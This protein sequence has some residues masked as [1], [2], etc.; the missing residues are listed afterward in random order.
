MDLQLPASS[1]G[2]FSLSRHLLLGTAG[3]IDHGKT[4]LVRVLTGTDTDRLPEEKARGM[5]IELGFAALEVG[6]AG[7]EAVRFGIVD[8]P[9]HE[10]FVRTMVAGATG[11]D[12]VLLVVAADDSVMPQT[13]EHVDILKLLNVRRGVV[14]ITKCDLVDPEMPA[15]VEEEVREL[16]AGSPLASAP[17][18]PVSAH[19]GVGLDVLRE[20]LLAEAGQIE[21]RRTSGIFRLPI[22]RVFTVHGRGTVVTG[23]A[24][25]GTVTVGQALELLPAR[26]PC[27]VR[28]LQTHSDNADLLHDGQRVAVNLAGIGREQIDRGD[29]LATVGYLTPSEYLDVEITALSANA[30]ALRHLQNVRL[31]MGTGEC[32]VRLRLLGGGSGSNRGR[33]V[34]GLAPG[35]RGFAQLQSERPVVAEWHQRFILRDETDSRTVGGGLVLRPVS[36]RLQRADAADIDGLGVLRSGDATAR[37]EEIIRFARVGRFAKGRGQLD[38]LSIASAAGISAEAIAPLLD[39]L[40]GQGRVR[41]LG[42]QGLLVPLAT[43]DRCARQAIEKLA[44]F[45]RGH[46]DDPGYS[47]PS[48]E[49]WVKRRWGDEV[50]G[51]LV[52]HLL[53]TGGWRADHPDCG[54]VRV[55][56]RYCCLSEF[57]PKMSAE[58]ERLLRAIIDEYRDAAFQPPSVTALRSTQSASSSRVTKL[59]KIAT[60]TGQLVRISPD[61]LM[62]PRCLEQLKA[63]LSAAFGAEG[64]TVAEVRTLIDSSRK[65][66]VPVLEYLDKT[67]FTRRVG[68]RRLPAEA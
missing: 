28:G 46:P 12:M 15:L 62:H 61:L 23:S 10:R 67:G 48:F 21:V 50:G 8:V 32:L 45:H 5:T 51:F 52:E 53:G 17:I 3:H 33:R 68:D 44:Q 30:K 64:V 39:Q 1:D 47:L 7:G 18:V 20:A 49:G 34:F 42:D 24:L 58:D 41:L 11:I 63:R 40:I 25:S 36:R 9:G 31:C 26:I 22:D 57:A 29:E 27:R 59:L 35:D 6:R 56:G 19:T 37:L 43:L 65:Y 54:R 2:K 14:A 16:L 38:E 55:I 60:A 66:V 4:T 13:R